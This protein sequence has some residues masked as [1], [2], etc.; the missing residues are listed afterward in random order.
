[1]TISSDNCDIPSDSS[2]TY[3]VPDTGTKTTDALELFTDTTSNT[4]CNYSYVE[5]AV[6]NWTASYDPT[7]PQSIPLNNNNPGASNLRVALLNTAYYQPVTSP[8]KTASPTH[9]ATPT[10]KPTH[11]ATVR[12]TVKATHRV[13][14]TA[15]TLPDTGGSHIGVTA[16]IGGLLVLIGIW[17]VVAPSAA[18]RRRPG[19]HS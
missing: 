6:T 5:T 7:A 8:T 12:A 17:L 16:W 10:K 4:A 14:P 15:T 19:Q 11:R 3:Q 18:R 9:S 1:V 2:T 13:T